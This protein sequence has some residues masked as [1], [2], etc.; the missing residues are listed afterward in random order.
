MRTNTEFICVG[1]RVVAI[2]NTRASVLPLACKIGQARVSL[3][4]DGVAFMRNGRPIMY[5]I[6]LNHRSFA[7]HLDLLTAMYRLRRRVFKDRLDWTVSISGDVELDAYDTLNPTYLLAM[8]DTNKVAGCVRLLPS[9]GPTMLVDTF[10]MLLG[11]KTPPSDQRILESSR[12]CVDT[13]LASELSERGLNRA[14]F[15]L[16]AAMI[17]TA[18]AAGADAIMTVTDTRM[19]RILRRAGWSLDR[20]APPQHLGNTM[21]LAGFLPV[22]AEALIAMYRGAETAGPVIIETAVERAVA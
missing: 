1:G 20:I 7:Q 14:T 10:P 21:A 11:G 3:F 6:S 19:E 2:T 12:F 13:K 4:F 5:V 18:Q 17:E 9:T 15:L 16:F 8:T 22:S